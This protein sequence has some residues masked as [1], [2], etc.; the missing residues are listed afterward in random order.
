MST[1]HNTKHHRT[2][3]GYGRR[4]AKRGESN[5]S[6][7]M[8]DYVGVDKAARQAEGKLRSIRSK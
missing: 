7:R 1:K 6:V 2:T 8:H 5:V 3:G 4:L